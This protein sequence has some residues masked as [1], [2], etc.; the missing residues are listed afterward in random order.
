[1]TLKTFDR[2][3]EG[4][5]DALMSEM[6]DI[7]AGVATP[8]EAQAFAILAEKVIRSLEADLS[9]SRLEDERKR[10]EYEKQERIRKREAKQL[11]LL[12]EQK[13][14]Q[15]SGPVSEVSYAS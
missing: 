10:V 2:T 13:T 7:R 12:I 6:E 11:R 9:A 15:I 8:A 3:S 4:L 5:R 14:L 1:M